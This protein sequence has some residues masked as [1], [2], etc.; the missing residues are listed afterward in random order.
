MIAGLVLYSSFFFLS[1]QVIGLASLTKRI[2]MF[3][4][5]MNAE[6]EM[7]LAKPLVSRIAI[8]ILFSSSSKALGQQK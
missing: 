7:K 6:E 8:Y 4:F 2:L 3:M 1:W 5:V